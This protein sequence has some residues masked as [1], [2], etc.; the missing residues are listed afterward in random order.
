MEDVVIRVGCVPEHFSCPLYAAQEAGL[1]TKDGFKVQLVDCPG[2][3]GEMTRLLAENKIDLAIALTEGLVAPLARAASI[4]GATAAAAAPDPGYRIVGSYTDSP[5]TWAVAI[6]PGR[7]AAGAFAVPAGGAAVD[8]LRGVRIGVSR[9]GSGSH[10]VPFVVA[11]ERGWLSQQPPQGENADVA[12]AAPF[13]FVPLANID[14]LRKSIV[15]GAADAFLWERIMTK[16]YFDSG[17][18]H[19]LTDVTPPW[20]AFLVAGNTQFLSGVGNAAAAA[21]LLAEFGRACAEFAAPER[22]PESVEFVARRLH[23]SDTRDVEDWFSGVRFAADPAAVQRD[24]VRGCVR[25]LAGAGV[26][27]SATGG[28]VVAAPDGEFDEWFFGGKA[29]VV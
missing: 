14:G 2:G 24:V 28:A 16:R 10:I 17:E 13:E 7:H 6:N 1:F 5:L 8:A 23:F 25:V 18:L 21:R 4:A 29:R 9:L 12:A 27:A 20:P 19:H 11:A 15:D 3:T 26:V 22:R